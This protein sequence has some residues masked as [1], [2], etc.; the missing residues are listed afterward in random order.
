MKAAAGKKDMA[1]FVCAAGTMAHYVGDAC[2]PLHISRMFDGD[3]GDTEIVK[4][5]NPKTGKMEDVEQPRAAGVH[6]S[7]EKDMVERHV[8]EIIQG[9]TGIAATQEPL[10]KDGRAAA[11]AL[12]ALMRATFADIPPQEIVRDFQSLR[13][14]RRKAC[15]HRGRAVE[16]VRQDDGCEYGRRVQAP[17]PPVGECV[18]SKA[19]ATRRA[20]TTPCLKSGLT[21]CTDPDFVR[22]LMLDEIAEVLD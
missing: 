6:S 15:S 16:V 21:A 2:Q 8:F 1:R 19:V 12:V 11:I 5:R 22:S 13:D 17:G 14:Q 20:S 4:K 18:G 3:P 7:Y 9:L 10:L